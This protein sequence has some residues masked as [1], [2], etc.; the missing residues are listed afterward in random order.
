MSL[1]TDHLH[2]DLPRRSV[3]SG[4]VVMVAQ[5]I[6]ILIGIGSV[7]I[8][9]RLLTPAE[10]GV[11]AIASS[12][13]AFVTM[14][15]DNGLPQSIVQREDITERQL[16]AIFWLNV[17]G[18]LVAAM[19]GALIAWPISL[20]FERPELFA[21]IA[22]LAASLVFTGLGAPHAALLRRQ[23]RFRTHSMIGVVANALGVIA[24]IIAALAGWGYWALV[25]LTVVMT[26]ARAA[27]A[28]MFSGWCPGLPGLAPGIGPMVRMGAYLSGTSLVG[29]ISRTTDRILIGYGLG[30]AAAGFYSNANRLIL[31]PTTQIN[32][33]LTSVAI[34]VLSRL[35]DQ[36]ERFRSF[37][38]RGVEAVVFFLSPF[39]LVAMVTADHLVPLF[40]GPQWMESIPI[41]Q[42]LTPA[43]LVACTRIVTSWIYIPL[44]HTDRQFRWRI[45]AS[46]VMVGAFL[47]G[48]NWGAVGVAL[49][50]SIQ[51]AIIRGPAIAYCLHGT[52]VRGRDVGAAL[53]RTGVASAVTVVT[54]LL[55]G[56]MLPESFGDLGSCVV[57]TVIV[58][59]VYVLAFLLTPGGYGRLRSMKEILHHLRG[60]SGTT[61]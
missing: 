61:S 56:P 11:V 3:R 5:A 16:N 18:G 48:L 51:A 43:A 58:F 33:P 7:S 40:L 12:F 2:A 45:F 13:V 15:A 24:A 20:L 14:F 26:M 55:V 60:R 27:G 52:F 23:L 46:L 9:G 25:V 34:P 19:L 29:T 53:W 59:L 54:G 50:Y 4:A 44:G 10:F 42:A 22:T 37:Y 8:L 30:N 47:V 41:F 36:Q 57:M 28:W 31:V 17:A 38:R 21:V 39:V 32:T 6:T 1:K 35:Q 49:A